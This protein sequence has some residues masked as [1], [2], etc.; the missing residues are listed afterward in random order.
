MLDAAHTKRCGPRATPSITTVATALFCVLLLLSQTMVYAQTATAEIWGRVSD[1]DGKAIPRAAVTVVN[2]ETGERRHLLTADG[3]RFAAPALSIGRY[4]V[5][6]AADPY[7]ARR[8]D[9]IVLV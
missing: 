5:A 4:Q 3:E 1:P 7:A 8:Q 9:D 2:V 6:A